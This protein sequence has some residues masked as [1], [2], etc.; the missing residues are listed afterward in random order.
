MDY[1][2]AYDVA[3]NVP[4]AT[5]HDTRD[6]AYFDQ[7]MQ[8][9]KGSRPTSTILKPGRYLDA[10][11]NGTFGSESGEDYGGIILF[12]CPANERQRYNVT[13]SLIG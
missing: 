9:Q 3:T 13:S 11:N 4:C 2:F 10:K 8:T 12:M 6:P 1:G 5:L 7:H